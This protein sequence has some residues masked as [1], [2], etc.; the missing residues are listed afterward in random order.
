MQATGLL[1]DLVLLIT[2]VRHV[3]IFIVVVMA[4]LVVMSEW[5]RLRHLLFDWRFPSI[6]PLFD[7]QF[8]SISP[9]VDWLFSLKQSL[10]DW[11]FPST[12]SYAH[13]CSWEEVVEQS[14][15]LRSNRWHNPLQEGNPLHERVMSTLNMNEFTASVQGMGCE[16]FQVFSQRFRDLAKSVHPDRYRT[17]LD[18]KCATRVMAAL[19]VYKELLKNRVFPGGK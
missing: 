14:D 18:Q 2:S 10:F 17:A 7:W 11:L 16:G 6:Q 12:Q 5:P 19:N 13:A 8:P 4:A 9:L 15:S 1:L 3:L